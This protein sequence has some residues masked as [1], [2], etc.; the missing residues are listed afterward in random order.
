M[1]DPAA[2]TKLLRAVCA[3]VD[4]KRRV[5]CN[6]LR[7]CLWASGFLRWS[8]LRSTDL[9][10]FVLTSQVK[11]RRIP[12]PRYEIGRS[13]LCSMVSARSFEAKGLLPGTTYRLRVRSN[14]PPDMEPGPWSPTAAIATE[15]ISELAAPRAHKN[16]SKL[17]RRLSKQM[18]SLHQEADKWQGL[19]MR[20]AVASL[21]VALVL[22]TAFLQWG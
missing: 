13:L 10:A 19:P 14:G 5:L 1:S 8:V 18:T 3:K 2:R 7:T 22:L 6:S 16:P 11:L 20:R 15:A 4:I 9:R 21:C 12:L 17:Q